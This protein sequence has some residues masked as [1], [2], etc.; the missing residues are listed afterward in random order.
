MAAARSDGVSVEEENRALLALAAGARAAGKL[1]LD[2]EFMGEGRYRTLLCLIQLAIPDGAATRRADRGLRPARGGPRRRAAG[3]GAR[4]SGDRGRRARRAPGHRA[5]AQ[6]LRHGGD[7]TSSTRRS[8]PASPGWGRNPPMSRCWRRSSA[9]AWPRAR[10]SRAGTRARCR[11]SSWPTRAR[12]SSTCS[13]SPAELERRLAELGRLEWAREEC[14][15]LERSSDER[16]P[17]T[18]FARLPR[19]RSLSA[20][21]RPIARELVQWREQ[22]AARQDRPVQGASSATPR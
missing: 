15:P 6:A 8:R 17:E 1:A 13:S 7:A 11:P 16:D 19:V 2:T 9:C 21:A 20:S 5:G 3:R 10:A 14:E 4:R 12:T 22:T 18:I